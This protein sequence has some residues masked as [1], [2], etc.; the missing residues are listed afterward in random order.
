MYLGTNAFLPGEDSS[1]HFYH[2]PLLQIFLYSAVYLH[3][4]SVAY[5]FVHDL[6]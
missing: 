4:G 2:P 3:Y 1:Y 6:L 5:T